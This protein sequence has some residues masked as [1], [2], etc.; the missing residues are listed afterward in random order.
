[1]NPL[2]AVAEIEIIRIGRPKEGV[3]VG[4]VVLAAGFWTPNLNALVE[5]FE[6]V[7]PIVIPTFLSV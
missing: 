2:R 3:G 4:F 5:F 7:V 1:M 6:V